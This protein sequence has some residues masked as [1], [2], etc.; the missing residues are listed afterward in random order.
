MEQSV[1]LVSPQIFFQPVFN[2][3]V[4]RDGG[5]VRRSM[6]EVDRAVGRAAFLHEVRRRGWHAIENAG[7]ITVF[8]NTEP[9]RVLC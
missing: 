6:A 5:I 3:R 9:F 1:R 8:C 4:V 7:W 2:D